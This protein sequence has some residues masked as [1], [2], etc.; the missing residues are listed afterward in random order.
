MLAIYLSPIF[1]LP[2]QLGRWIV[3]GLVNP[4]SYA[5]TSFKYALTGNPDFLMLGP[6]ADVAVLAFIAVG[7]WLVE[8]WVLKQIRQRG[9]DRVV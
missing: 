6:L 2:S 8:R 5:L 7:A 1:Y 3:V 4:F 9:I